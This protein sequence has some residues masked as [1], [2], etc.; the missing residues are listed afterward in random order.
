MIKSV[1][2]VIS[3]ITVLESVPVDISNIGEHP[4][5]PKNY[6]TNCRNLDP[7]G[8][9]RKV[10]LQVDSLIADMRVFI[11]Y[12]LAVPKMSVYCLLSGAQP[13]IPPNLYNWVYEHYNYSFILL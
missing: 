3:L 11:V 6:R 1:L 7:L 9:S 5:R 13:V 10:F 12:T 8:K 2:L 4:L